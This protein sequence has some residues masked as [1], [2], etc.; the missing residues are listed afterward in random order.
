VTALTPEKLLIKDRLA[1]LRPQLVGLANY[2]HANPELAFAEHKAAQTVAEFAAGQGFAVTKGVAGLPTAMHGCAGSGPVAIGFCAEY[3]A[4]P[5]LGHACGHNLIA[6][7]GAGAAAAML[8]VA[9]AAGLTVHLFGT[10]AEEVLDGGGKILMF[11]AG[12]F[13]GMN[14]LLMAHPA[15]FDAVAPPLS[16]GG[17]WTFQYSGT[18]GHVFGGQ[19]G[20]TAL[21]DAMLIA[22]T[23]VALLDRRLGFGHA[24]R[25]RRVPGQGAVNV[26][27]ENLEARFAVRAPNIRALLDVAEALRHCFE[28]GALATGTRLS[29]AG[30]AKP[31]AEMH[32]NPELARLYRQNAEMLGR[33]FREPVPPLGITSDLGNASLIIPALHPFI[34]LDAGQAANHERAF[35]SYCIGPAAETCLMDAALALAW[36]ALDFAAAAHS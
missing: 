14:A 23:A 34:G 4:L 20:G 27:D 24:V 18:A 21:Q 2:I 19:P 25:G 22:E 36:T 6:A 30:G 17:A 5:G 26:S 16:A 28:A 29:V 10:P 11:E 35:A 1:A 9:K 7:I 15:P 8:P 3:D 31:Y 32:Q 13:D 12:C 33:I